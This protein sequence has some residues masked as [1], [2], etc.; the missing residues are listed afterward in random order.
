M[1]NI[2]ILGLPHALLI[3][4]KWIL[5]SAAFFHPRSD[6]V[7]SAFTCQAL[8]VIF[9]ALSCADLL[10]LYHVVVVIPAKSTALYTTIV[11]IHVV[12]GLV[13]WDFMGFERPVDVSLAELAGFTLV[14][15]YAI[16]FIMT[17]FL[18]AM[19]PI[20]EPA[21]EAQ[22]EPIV[23]EQ[24]V[25]VPVNSSTRARPRKKT[26]TTRLEYLEISNHSPTA[27]TYARFRDAPVPAACI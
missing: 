24:V 17:T 26:F 21:I 23:Q 3:A 10:R 25:P 5:V 20:L 22:P 8:L 2:T 14:Y 15:S 19:P 12:I 1:T 13:L 7:F 18:L 6:E 16:I 4:T 11:I 9:T 27:D